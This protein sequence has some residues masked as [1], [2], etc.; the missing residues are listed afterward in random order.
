MPAT[1]WTGSNL[2][3]TNGSKTVT[4]NTGSPLTSIRPNSSLT[5]SNY[6]EPVEI[7]SAVGNTITLYSPWPGST[8]TFAATITP[9]AATV[10]AAGQAAQ[11]VV[12]EIKTL[13][14]GSS[15]AASANSFVKRD[16]NGCVKTA[17]PEE[18]DD[19]VN[20][21]H[22]TSQLNSVAQ[23]F[24]VSSPNSQEAYVGKVLYGGFGAVTTGGVADWND[25]T[26][27]RPGCGYSLLRG[28]QANGNGNPAFFHT[29][30]FEYASK[31]GTGNLAQFGVG[32]NSPELI[33][34]NRFGGIW[35]GWAR[36]FNDKNLNV[37][38]FGD[39]IGS[40]V[41]HGYNASVS[42]SV[43]YQSLNSRFG[44]TGI[45]VVGTFS[46]IGASGAVIR[47]GITSADIVMAVQSGNRLLKLFVNGSTGLTVNEPV[48]LRT[49]SNASRITVNF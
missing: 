44:P 19:A 7:E 23:S 32:Y 28:D 34:R 38:T 26:N 13:V 49:E 9:S 36:F 25:V 24:P 41:F 15:V 30:S 39:L 43:V 46:L 31:D 2:S 17:T 11:E 35:D 33:M 47:S 3:F 20:K 10:A 12:Q 42:T 8:G 6:N 27:A 37:S 29:F 16:T 22:L 48:E 21:G 5:T 4:V 1:F 40:L 18:N 14:S 45:S